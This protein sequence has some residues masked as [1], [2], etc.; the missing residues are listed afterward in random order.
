MK[1]E[2][3]ASISLAEKG[4]PRRV[5]KIII[6]VIGL[7]ADVCFRRHPPPSYGN[8]TVSTECSLYFLLM[9]PVKTTLSN[10][11]PIL[12]ISQVRIGLLHCFL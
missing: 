5:Q 3:Y 10:W 9:S 12:L 4:G 11:D 6:H 1:P 7:R 8:I 2:T